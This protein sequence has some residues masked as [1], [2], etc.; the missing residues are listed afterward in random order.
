MSIDKKKEEIFIPTNLPTAGYRKK[1]IDLLKK[2]T[3]GLTIADITKHLGTTRHTT[4]IIL[5]EL[6]GARLIGIRKIGMAK[7]HHWRDE[8]E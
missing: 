8:E 5:A 6:R 7:L 1:I 3:S 4:S 2:D